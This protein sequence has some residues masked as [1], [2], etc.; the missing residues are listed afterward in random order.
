VTTPSTSGT[1]WPQ[2]DGKV[3]EKMAKV[4]LNVI[5]IG[6]AVVVAMLLGLATNALPVFLI[7]LAALAVLGL[8][9]GG[10]RW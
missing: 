5:F 6:A 9:V 1:A 3:E 8:L 7:A 2:V 10:I 4:K